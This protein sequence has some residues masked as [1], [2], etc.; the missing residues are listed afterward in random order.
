MITSAEKKQKTKKTHQG[1]QTET[2]LKQVQ[3]HQ[4]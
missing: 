3:L 2:G 1:L 4:H